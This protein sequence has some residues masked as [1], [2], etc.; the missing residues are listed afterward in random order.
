MHPFFHIFLNWISFFKKYRL[1]PQL[2]WAFEHGYRSRLEEKSERLIEVLP[3]YIACFKF[4]EIV[5]YVEFI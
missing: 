5:V 2:T 3:L 4:N 1:Q